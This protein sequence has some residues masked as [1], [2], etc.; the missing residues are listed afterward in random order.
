MAGL[1]PTGLE[2]KTLEEIKGEMETAF[3]AAISPALDV[4]A[5]PTKEEIGIPADRFAALWE[6]ALS[7]Y[8]AWNPN[9]ATD[10]ALDQICALTG[11]ERNAATKSQLT[12]AFSNP[13]SVNINAGVTLPA[14]TVAAVLGNP[15]AQFITLEA[16]TNPGPGA[17]DFDVDMQ[18]IDAGPVA[19][20]AGTLTV[21]VTSVAG[22]N[23]I[24]NPLDAELGALAE[25]DSARRIRRGREL[26]GAG[27]STEPGLNAEFSDASSGL[28]IDE[29]VIFQNDSDVV[30]IAGRPPHSIELVILGGDDVAI[31]QLLWDKKPT[32]IQTHRDPGASGVTVEILD[33]GGNTKE[34]NFTRPTLV[35][36][37]FTVDMTK[38][39]RGDG[40]VLAIRKRHRQRCYWESILRINPVDSWGV[41]H[42]CHSNVG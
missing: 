13:A 39:Q 28:G 12:D 11:T 15:D 9:D 19:A 36:I 20:F 40:C 23:S 30:D 35:P 10:T 38:I 8:A 21:Q 25:L 31:G 5:T 41:E 26:A 3:Q 37:V 34:A 29:F 14:G 16:V 22:W 27:G 24:T 4:N 17:A 33:S 18:A 32:G 42:Q 6:L 2:I 1:G 7:I